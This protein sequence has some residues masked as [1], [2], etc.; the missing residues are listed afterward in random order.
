MGDEAVKCARNGDKRMTIYPPITF[1]NEKSPGKDAPIML[2]LRY[3]REKSISLIRH[4]IGFVQMQS[5]WGIDDGDLAMGQNSD[6]EGARTAASVLVTALTIFD[7]MLGPAQMEDGTRVDAKAYVRFIPHD[8]H[9]K[10]V[11][12]GRIRSAELRDKAREAICRYSTAERRENDAI[13]RAAKFEKRANKLKCDF[14]ENV[15]KAYIK[16]EEAI[17]QQGLFIP[18]DTTRKEAA[19]MFKEYF[20]GAEPSVKGVNLPPALKRLYEDFDGEEK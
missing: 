19:A 17:K 1:G 11:D 3:V 12:E 7:D 20:D 14:E 2:R 4:F 5:I 9:K 16:A 10:A 15:A 6:I 18:K 13:R 8:E